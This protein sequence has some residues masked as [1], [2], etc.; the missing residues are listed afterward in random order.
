MH[1]GV[2]EVKALLHEMLRAYEWGVDERYTMPLDTTSRPRPA[3]GLPV[4][5]SPAG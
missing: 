1:F 4:R 5:L 3:D 2:L